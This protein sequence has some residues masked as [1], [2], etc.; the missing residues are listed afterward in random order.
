MEKW[1]I[2]YTVCGNFI[3]KPTDDDGDKVVLEPAFSWINETVQLQNG[4]TGIMRQVI[5][6]QYSLA[7]S[8]LEIKYVG[9]QDLSEWPEYS[10][11]EVMNMVNKALDMIEAA[12]ASQRSN[13]VS[14][15][16]SN[17]VSI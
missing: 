17:I 13:I 16:K 11:K 14:P 6:I 12:E 2:Y 1:K 4:Q 15:K 5:P 9:V 8:K 3:G 7:A 10:S